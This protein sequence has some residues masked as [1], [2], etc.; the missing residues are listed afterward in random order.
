MGCVFL[1]LGSARVKMITISQNRLSTLI[2]CVR[3]E[4]VGKRETF[5]QA[6]GERESLLPQMKFGEKENDGE[7]EST[8]HPFVINWSNKQYLIAQRIQQQKLYFLPNV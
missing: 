7:L 2:D 1:L 5:G 8:G 6:G 4:S 3:I